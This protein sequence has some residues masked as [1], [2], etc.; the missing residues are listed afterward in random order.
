MKTDR[1][2][3]PRRSAGNHIDA[4]A[5]ALAPLA[6]A[7]APFVAAEV[8][9]IGTAGEFTTESPPPAIS[10]KTFHAVCRSGIVLGATKDGR[11]WRCTREAWF[12]ARTPKVARSPGVED[13][14][15]ACADQ[16]LADAGLRRTG[17]R[18]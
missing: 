10:A 9:K 13:D 4:I 6:R 16:F 15:A 12:A 3:T 5:S 11:S 8:A 14:D 17:G 2:L 7:L 1:R 18:Q